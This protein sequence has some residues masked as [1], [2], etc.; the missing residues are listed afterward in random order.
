MGPVGSGALAKL[1]INLPLLVFW[2]SFGEALALANDLGRD[3]EWLVQL[4]TET[5]GGRHRVWLATSTGISDF[6]V[7]IEVLRV[8][9]GFAALAALNYWAVALL[10]LAQSSICFARSGLG[11]SEGTSGAAARGRVHLSGV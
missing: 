11:R 8:C 10:G 1:A 3:P 9:L 6:G 7:R 4:F 2:Q 5:A